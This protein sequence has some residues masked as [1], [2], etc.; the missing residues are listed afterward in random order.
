M[1]LYDKSHITLSSRHGFDC[2]RRSLQPIINHQYLQE[3]TP[4]LMMRNDLLFISDDEV[5]ASLDAYKKGLKA[6]PR[7][8]IKNPT[9]NMPSYLE[10]FFIDCY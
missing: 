3:V 4:M 7:G 10:H 8:K 1:Q 6:K 9:G 5:L 2:K